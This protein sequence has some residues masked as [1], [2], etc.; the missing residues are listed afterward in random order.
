[1]IY[2]TTRVNSFTIFLL[3]LCYCRQNLCQVNRQFFRRT[4][5]FSS[6]KVCVKEICSADNKSKTVIRHVECLRVIKINSLSNTCNKCADHKRFKKSDHSKTLANSEKENINPDTQQN[7][8]EQ[9][10]K[11]APNLHENQI[12]LIASQIMSS[13]STSKH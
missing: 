9:L 2:A 6:S 13:N 3:S 5:I 8:N 12:T 7:A 11:I 4:D 1:V 10:R